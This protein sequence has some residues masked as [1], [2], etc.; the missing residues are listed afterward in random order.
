M[1]NTF[2]NFIDE[3]YEIVVYDFGDVER[4]ANEC[5]IAI[6]SVDE[7]IDDGSDDGED[8]YVMCCSFYAKHNDTNE[9]KMVRIYFGDRTREI[10]Y[11]SIQ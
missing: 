7:Y 3:L 9:I 6:S 1:Q 10:G 5:N 4:L 2:D 8:D 11:V